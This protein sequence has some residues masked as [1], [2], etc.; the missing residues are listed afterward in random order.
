MGKEH[1]LLFLFRGN[2]VGSEKTSLISGR[3][4]PHHRD[5]ALEI[6]ETAQC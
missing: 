4:L 6:K 2:K 1:P 5:F 3:P